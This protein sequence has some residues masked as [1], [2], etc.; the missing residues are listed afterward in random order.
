MGDGGRLVA[1]YKELRVKY[2]LFR[3]EHLKQRERMR[4]VEQEMEDREREAQAA[5]REMQA[6][7]EQRRAMKHENETLAKMNGELAELNETYKFELD[8]LE[9]QLARLLPD[10]KRKANAR[11]LLASR[12]RESS[13][14]R[15]STQRALYANRI[16]N[17]DVVTRIQ[18][19]DTPFYDEEQVQRQKLQLLEEVHTILNDAET[20]T[21]H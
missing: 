14:S 3:M 21:D 18:G 1:F 17:R 11:V 15:L 13:D 2:R 20:Q 4:A 5:R 12:R 9:V 8:K 6:S 19:V 7:E 10:R 16:A